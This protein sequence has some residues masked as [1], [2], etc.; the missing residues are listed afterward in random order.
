M[1]SEKIR[2]YYRNTKLDK[3]LVE[4]KIER[5]TQHKDIMQEFEYWIDTKQYKSDGIVVEGYSAKS[6]AQI[7][8]FLDGEAAFVY[9]IELRENP[10]KA[11]R[12]IAN[13]FKMK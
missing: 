8:V 7:S 9:L 6:L 5:F 1:M 11:L 12:E 2:E 13:G 10:E 3:H 4:R